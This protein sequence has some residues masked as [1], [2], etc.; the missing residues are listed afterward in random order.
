MNGKQ[1]MNIWEQQCS[2]ANTALRNLACEK[3]G[4]ETTS[5]QILARGRE[6]HYWIIARNM[7]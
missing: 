1:L 7:K 5:Y 3:C 4:F 2:N 6:K